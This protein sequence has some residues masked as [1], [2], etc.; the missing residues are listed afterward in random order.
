MAGPRCGSLEKEP[1]VSIATPSLNQSKFI[2][3]TIESVESQDYKAIE[4]IVIDGRSTDETLEILKSASNRNKR[5]RWISERDNGQSSAINKAWRMA[6]GQI[7]GWLNSDDTYRP[8]AVSRAV[9]FMVR[10]PEVNAVYGDCDYIDEDGGFLYRYPAREFDFHD[11]VRTTENFIP[12]PSVFFRREI[13]DSVGYLNESLHKVMDLEFWLRIGLKCDM[14]FL[15]KNMATL[16]LHGSSKTISESAGFSGEL[17]EVYEEFFDS[18]D[19]SLDIKASRKEAMSN[20]YY[21]AAS[22]LYWAGQFEEAFRMG[23][24]AWRFRLGRFRPLYLF[25]PLKGLGLPLAKKTR[26]RFFFGK[27]VEREK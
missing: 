3:E 14:V 5:L 2:S 16:R 21:K 23:W 6:K 26:R 7:L 18:P 24:R 25:F 19:V 4:H 1:L 10:N 11:L 15:K 20:V 27:L 13:L 22:Y 9:E 12:Q 17:I 8:G